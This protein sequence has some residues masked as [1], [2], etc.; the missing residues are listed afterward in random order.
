MSAR[1]LVHRVAPGES[2]QANLIP[3]LPTH[4]ERAPSIAAVGSFPFDRPECGS[5]N[6]TIAVLRIGGP[7]PRGN[8]VRAVRLNRA[9]PELPPQL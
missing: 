2:P 1:R 8:A 6:L 3:L 4:P 9:S 7:E 5:H